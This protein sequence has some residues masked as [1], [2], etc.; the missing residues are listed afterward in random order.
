MKKQTRSFYLA[1]LLLAAFLLWTA[2]VRW[3]DVQ[4]I[5]PHGSAVG[6]AT[7]NRFIHTLTGVHM[8]LYVITDWLGLIPFGFVVG[9]G[10]LGLIQWIRRKSLLRV[11]R[12]ILALGGF[13]VVVLAAYLF[14]EVLVINYRPVLINGCLEASYPSSTT[15]LALCVMSTAMLQLKAR[16]ENRVLRRWLLLV[17]SAFTVFLVVGRLLCGVH[18][19]TDIMGGTLLSGGL[20][21][22]YAAFTR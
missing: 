8:T 1:L 5:G 4:A 10:I 11:D 9:F 12:S 14:F 21:L 18:W 2:A 13:Y 20:V 17:F 22:L 7:L 16:I 6:F 19:F 3:V 15:T